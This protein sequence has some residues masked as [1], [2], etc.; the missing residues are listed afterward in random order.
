MFW[1]LFAFLLSV[2][3]LRAH[4]SNHSTQFG[5]VCFRGTRLVC[6]CPVLLSWSVLNALGEW[7]TSHGWKGRL[8]PA[9]RTGWC[10][11]RARPIRRGCMSILPVLFSVSPVPSCCVRL[12]HFHLHAQRFCCFIQP[13]HSKE[14]IFHKSSLTYSNI[15]ARSCSKHVALGDILIRSW[16][17]L[18][19]SSL[20]VGFCLQR[21]TQREPH[22]TLCHR[23]LHG[24]KVGT[25]L[26]S[27]SK[28]RVS[29]FD[30]KASCSCSVGL[31][32]F[33][34]PNFSPN[35]CFCANYSNH[36]AIAMSLQAT[37]IALAPSFCV[38]PP[39]SV[40]FSCRLCLVRSTF[41]CESGLRFVPDGNFSTYHFRHVRPLRLRPNALHFLYSSPVPFTFPSVRHQN[42]SSWFS[43]GEPVFFR[44]FLCMSEPRFL[45]QFHCIQQRR[46]FKVC[47]LYQ[48][49]A[50]WVV[51]W[52]VRHWSANKHFMILRSTQRSWHHCFSFVLISLFNWWTWH[53]PFR[54]IISIWIRKCSGWVQPQ[55]SQLHW[56][57]V[58]SRRILRRSA[59]WHL[60]RRASPWTL[61]LCE[62][63]RR[64]FNLRFP[65]TFSAARLK[66][67]SMP[68][69]KHMLTSPV[70]PKASL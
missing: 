34:S 15:S 61:H 9:I 59:W 65:I 56:Q 23:C 17:S 26:C 52:D 32:D 2:Y 6:A 67:S 42:P 68:M 63:C 12:L 13:Y 16:K 70:L 3:L 55:V 22:T 30:E 58:G 10:C 46:C 31:L 8:D 28:Y 40:S 7:G 48:N 36:L 35:G 38:L 25:P 20:L 57:H 19:T 39:A 43:H 5:S 1:F 49:G 33:L 41:H 11:A 60:R 45:L 18:L 51:P 69:L 50:F 44:I 21:G 47:K 27:L 37:R 53:L 29:H 66:A 4:P 62:N 14:F 54:G 24:T 64:R